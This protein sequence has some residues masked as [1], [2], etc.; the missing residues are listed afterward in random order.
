MNPEPLYVF[1]A[2]D[3]QRLLHEN[4]IDL[5]TELRRQGVI[6]RASYQTDPSASGIE[7]SRD[8]T[9]VLL[10]S[11][12]AF[13]SIALGIERIISS[14]SRNK[15]VVVRGRKCVPITLPG[16]EPVYDEHGRPMLQWV[17]DTKLLEARPEPSQ[18]NT[19]KAS[20]GGPAGLSIEISNTGA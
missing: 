18:E 19:F 12:A 16:G 4:A 15:K 11:G 8:L 6:A 7:T 20:L 5:T 14:L 13:Y 10:A 1:L 2:D 17:D 9:L 3:V